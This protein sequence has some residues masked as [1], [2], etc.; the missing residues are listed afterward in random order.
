MTTLQ[1]INLDILPDL[2]ASWK[3]REILGENNIWFDKNKLFPII[4]LSSNFSEDEIISKVREFFN[5]QSNIQSKDEVNL[6]TFIKIKNKR[7]KNLHIPTGII[8]RSDSK[9]RIFNILK[10]M[11]SDNY[12]KDTLFIHP[13]IQGKDIAPIP[14]A[15]ENQR[16]SVKMGVDS[17]DV[18]LA[19]NLV[20]HKLMW[21]SIENLHRMEVE[22]V[23]SKKDVDII[24]N[25]N[26]RCYF[27][28]DMWRKGN[29]GAFKLLIPIFGK[30]K[31]LFR[32]LY[33]RGFPGGS[34]SGYAYFEFEKNI[35]E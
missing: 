18:P 16:Q 28:K 9:D 6:R 20:I 10:E 1:G 30:D 19:C 11:P 12:I 25:T 15:C 17:S 34:A 4:E 13:F 24:K 31:I 14:F 8:G 27:V 5:V 29:E 3:L 26:I 33:K 22:E 21:S 35:F 7:K 2:M 32:K 23:K